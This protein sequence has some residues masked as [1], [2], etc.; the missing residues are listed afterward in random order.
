MPTLSS[1][2]LLAALAAAPDTAA[3]KDTAHVVTALRVEQAPALDGRLDEAAWAEAQPAPW[4]F[5]Q[6]R[7]NPGAPAS[8][9]TD[10]RVLYDAG[11]VYVGVRMYDAR[12]DSVSGRLARRDQ[13]VYSDWFSVALDSYRDR[14]TAFVF[15][16]N[17]RGVK[18]DLRIVNDGDEDAGW[19]AVW[20][21]AT[22]V[23]AQGWTAEFRIPLSQLRYR[24]GADEQV[25]GINFDRRIA[26]RGERS[27]W[28]P[29]PPDQAG[30]VSRYGTLRGIRGLRAARALEVQPYT[31][32]R[33]TRAP[34]SADDPYHQP[35][36]WFGSVGGDVK[37]GITSDL[38]L[39]AT[40]NPDFGQV[41]ADPSQ[42][43]LSAF[44]T[45]L[46]EKRPFFTEGADIF[47]TGW[48]PLFYSRR[49]GRA[50]QGSAPGDAA[51]SDQPD[52]TT[53]LGAV[54]LTGKTRGWSLG[55]LNAVAG[56]ETARFMGPDGREE[57]AVVEPLTNYTVARVVRD[58]NRGG[59][60]IGAA[61]TST[62]RRLEPGDG[63]DFLR[64]S[65][66]AG[67]LDWRH[68]FGGGNYE[69][70]GGAQGSWIVG[71]DSAIALVQRDAGHYFQRPD[72][73]HLEY[74]PTRSSLGGYA[75]RL[76]VMKNGGG[77]WR[78][79]AWGHLY[80][81]GYEI[82]D[83]GFGFGGD[84]LRGYASVGYQQAR[85]GRVFQ[86]WYAEVA[87][88]AEW[89]FGGERMGVATH[90][91]AS[92]TLNSQWG[93][94]LFY[95]RSLGGLSPSELW[96]GPALLTP[97][98]HSMSFGVNTD[99]RK[100]LSGDAGAWV[101][102]EDGTGARAVEFWG[103]ATLRASERMQLSLQPGLGLNR[104][105]TQFVE[106]VA[107]GGRDHY[108]LA[109]LDQ[110]T[111]SLTARLDYSFT[112]TL[113]LQLYASPFISAGRYADFMRVADPRAARFGDRFHVFGAGEA[114]VEGNAE[115]GRM[116]RIDLDGDGARETA[117]GDP[118]FNVKEFR[119]NA[120]LRWEYRPGAALFVVWSQ[121]RSHYAPDGRMDAI[122]DAAD[123]FR[124][125]GTN[126]LLIKASYWLGL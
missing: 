56:R 116:V 76:G 49:I 11:A 107:Q 95:T 91:R 114:V 119:S 111:A 85:P 39:T 17:P 31:V 66:Y 28:A 47:D 5:V 20:D 53:I 38:T 62:Q 55:L 24:P 113:S 88:S 44:E 18:R 2:L 112:P 70:V 6:N 25:W 30:V 42:V 117:V 97:G 82:N 93:G 7:P 12:P 81:P 69:L 86:R 52:A 26:R 110:T 58:F 67:S 102:V 71:S 78:W 123:L 46:D 29:L 65:A 41:E 60:A 106:T 45:W 118:S 89:T 16:V 68:R 77:S 103:G 87:Q 124:S 99:R 37:Y 83:A 64:S 74:D 21:V 101:E 43:N 108:L 94:N 3:A 13:D 48:P 50:P 22:R 92:F 27:L 109:R 63:L 90:A 36:E 98:G 10:V 33:V 14:R 120:V 57:S 79:E 19:D 125:P 40:F 32:A 105:G 15:G 34:G 122:G 75:G 54:K 8:E 59:S 126:V 84:E 104:G 73:D 23:D 115:E 35:A 61:F 9:R 80:S 51:W 100:A 72:A 96:G 1:A 121:G 4:G